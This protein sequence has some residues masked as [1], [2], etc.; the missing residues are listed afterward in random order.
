MILELV[1]EVHVVRRSRA[2]HVHKINI[3]NNIIY[4][5]M[6]IAIIKSILL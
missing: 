6:Q 4:T 2:W 5:C 3:V 1:F